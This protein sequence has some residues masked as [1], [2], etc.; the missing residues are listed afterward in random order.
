MPARKIREWNVTADLTQGL[1]D[2]YARLDRVRARKLSRY[3]TDPVAFAADCIEWGESGLTPYQEEVLQALCEHKRVCIRSPHGAG[4]S[5]IVSVLTLWFA[6]TRDAVG[7]DWKIATTAGG[8]Q[9]LEQYLWPEIHKWAGK[10]RWEKLGRPP[11]KPNKELL[12]LNI[13]LESGHAFAVASN[14]PDRIEGAHAD[15]LLFVIDE[16]KAVQPSTFDA[17]EGAFASGTGT[18]FGLVTSTPGPPMGRFYDIHDGKPG[19][20]KWWTRHITIDEVVAA[21]RNNWEWVEEHRLLWGGTSAPFFNRVLGEFHADDETAIIPWS[22]VEAA[23]TRFEDHNARA[24]HTPSDSDFWALP[25]KLDRIGVDVARTGGDKTCLAFIA[26]DRVVDLRFERN[27]M[28]DQTA[29]MVETYLDENPGAV[30]I[31]D[32]DGLGVGVFDILR[33]DGYNALPFHASGEAKGWKDAAGEW[34][35]RNQRAAAWF[36]LRDRLDPRNT[37]TIEL[38]NT[39]VLIG[40]LTTPKRKKDVGMGTNLMLQVESKADVKKRLGRS[41][42]AGDAV[43]MGLYQQRPKRKARMVFAGRIA[44]PRLV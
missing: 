23:I 11:F 6:L 25:D 15:S 16:A 30:A 44:D 31:V 14:R 10:L 3:Y 32:A 21:G 18:V 34:K 1:L 22:W 42:D 37:P 20:T 2:A 8:W 28:I 17:I 13:H 4:K 38:P 9:Q 27:T 39:S 5:A 33:R 19:L 29:A 12:R 24:S 41:P 36:D 43:V 7:A 40:D 35:A 26:G